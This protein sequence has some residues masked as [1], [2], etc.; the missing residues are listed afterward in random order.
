[1]PTFL[2]VQSSWQE[3]KL[4]ADR[5]RLHA[6][7]GLTSIVCSK[8]NPLSLRQSIG[9]SRRRL[10]RQPDEPQR[11]LPQSLVCFGEFSLSL[12]FGSRPNS[13]TYFA[14]ATYSARTTSPMTLKSAGLLL[15][16]L[17]LNGEM[18]T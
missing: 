11:D 2:R 9:W 16:T 18:V 17:H 5:A 4:G 13:V 6:S 7:A 12:N 1:M 10:K 8:R 14:K 15:E 3:N